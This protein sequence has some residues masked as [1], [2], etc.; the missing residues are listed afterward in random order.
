MKHITKEQ[1]YQIEVYVKLG[2]A[3]DFIAKELNVHRST[4]FRE[5]ARNGQKRGKYSAQTAHGFS[6]ERKERLF[7]NR[8]FTA[9]CQKTVIEYLGE[10][11]SPEQISGYCRRMGIPMVSIERIYQFLREDKRCGGDLYKNLRHQLKHRKRPVGKHFPIAGR[12]SIEERPEVVG[13]KGRF[14]D[15]EMDT[16]IGAN[17]KGVILTLT[18]RKTNFIFIKKLDLGKNAKGLR[19]QIID[20][21]MP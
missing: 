14:G 6:E 18:E 3:K 12:V 7:A 17:Q 8:T 9:D 5:I 16:I 11:W 10:Q 1:R 4:V 19:N 13:S 21:L 15:W 20:L 2:K